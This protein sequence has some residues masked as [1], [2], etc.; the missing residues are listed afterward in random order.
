MIVD[1]LKRETGIKTTQQNKGVKTSTIRVLWYVLVLVQL[2]RLHFG[3][4]KSAFQGA[5][6]AS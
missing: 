4:V 5:F 3:Y 2:Y 1:L 6:T